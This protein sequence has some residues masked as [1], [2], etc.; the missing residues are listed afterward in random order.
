VTGAA[1]AVQVEESLTDL[2]ALAE[3]LEATGRLS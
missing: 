2:A 1:Y 3:D